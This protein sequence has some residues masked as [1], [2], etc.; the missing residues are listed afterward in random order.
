MQKRTEESWEDTIN[1]CKDQPKIIYRHVNNK[2]KQKQGISKL[3]V[4]GKMY[5]KE[6]DM[7]QMVNDCFQMMH[8][9]ERM[10]LEKE[11]VGKNATC[12]CDIT[13]DCTGSEENNGKLEMSKKS[14]GAD[15]VSNWI[16]KEYNQDLDGKL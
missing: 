10:F 2:Q 12:V 16:V 1:K 15:T 5:E 8:T 7:A 9:N 6:A 3:K 14:Q 4:N 13:D 11:E